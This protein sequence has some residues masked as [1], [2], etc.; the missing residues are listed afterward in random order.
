M[1]NNF[2]KIFLILLILTNKVLAEGLKFETQEIEIKDGGNLVLA[3]NGK[4]ISVEE[5]FEIDAEKFEYSKDKDILEAYNGIAYFKSDN[6][7]IEFDEIILDQSKFLTTARKNIKIIDLNEKI[8]IQTE[9]IS[10][11]KKKNILKS[12][13]LSTLIDKNRN[14]I[15]TSNFWYN[16]DD[17]I[18]KLKDV[19]LKDI[20]NNKFKID[21]AYLNTVS[22][23]LIGK[24]I[25]VNLNNKSFNK[26]NEP[27]IKGRSIIIENKQT[28]ITKGIF[29][30]CK[31]TDKCPP[32]ELA[33]G[34]IQHDTKNQMINYQNAFLKVYNVP[35]LYFPKFFHPDPTVKRKSGFL[36]PTI[37]S[38][39]NSG[40]YLSLP[41]FSAISQNKDMTFTPRFYSSDKIL[42]QTEY[43]Q[44]NFESSHISDVSLLKEKDLNSK[45]H[46]FYKYNKM[47]DIANFDEGNLNLKFEKTSNDTYLRGN[48]LISPIINSYDVLENTIN[49]DLYSE[50]LSLKSEIKVY[51]KLNEERNNDKFEYILPK[52]D[53][54]K[55]FKNNTILN[56][57][58]LLKS[59][60][61]IRSYSTNILEKVNI[62]NF[63]FNSN[64]KISDLGFYKNYDFVIKNVNSDSENSNNYEKDKDSYL[65]GLFQYNLSLPLVKENKNLLSIIKPKMALKISPN[66]TKDLSKSDG[67]RL[68]VNNIFS[69][70]RLSSN[71]AV[72]GGISLTLGNDFSI[73]DQKKSEE[74]LFVKFANNLRFE[75]NDDLPRNNQLGAKTSNFFGEILYKPNDIINTKYNVSAKN[76]L[77]DINYE[78]FIAEIS[79]NNFVTTFDYLNENSSV[80]RNSYLTSKSKLIFNDENSIQFSTRENKSSNLT[81]YYN[82]M[83]EYK[84]DCLAASIE[85]NKDY[86]NDRDIKP[87]ENIFF[88]LTIIPFGETSSPNLKN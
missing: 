9:Q 15:Q 68:D 33:A 49:L 73:F 11:D 53:I 80:N 46:F 67:N 61:F 34:K 48:K 74:I 41:Y 22:D 37:K 66:H 65:S 10:F 5:N 3:K 16:L 47:I 51:E 28:E 64:S 44:E 59:N 23:K 27:R 14:I 17:G 2:L 57:D 12:N 72:E 77:T 31:K 55:R 58:F 13:A 71:N 50:N 21:L 78:N 84:N 38:S 81:E 60:N 43:R 62:N 40:D 75:E 54:V 26:N 19:E 76:N 82:L 7:K 20:E 70:D 88:K 35:V 69:I 56:G 32:W 25:T 30:T 24:D 42:L 8:S 87:E 4:A 85:Y 79:I 18:L 6:L 1:K 86:Y 29:T 36:V 45:T 83:Y 52:I 63:I 39:P